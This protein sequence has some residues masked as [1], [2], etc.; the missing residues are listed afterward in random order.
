MRY[1]NYLFRTYK[2]LLFRIKY[3]NIQYYKTGKKSTL[4][5]VFSQEGQDLYLFSLL[6]KYI[7][8]NTNINFGFLDIGANHP[9]INSNSALFELFPNM[10]IYAFEPQEKY[11]ELWKN[12]RP[13]S[14]FMNK[15]VGEKNSSIKLFIPK[16][17]S[18]AYA[19]I[20]GGHS[21]IQDELVEK[22][23]EMITLDHFMDSKKSTKFICA[24]IDVE[25]YELEVLKGINLNK[26]RIGVL[27]LENNC[28]NI[29]G[30]DNIRKFII[31][32]DYRYIAR[33]GYYDDV[34]VSEDFFKNL[35][36]K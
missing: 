12:E 30:D 11:L 35:N 7:L 26:N 17:E 4:L 22:C 36:I 13:K 1:L 29:F 5:N 24:S 14:V 32:N 34:F 25:G 2:Y 28:K 33:I 16:N 6:S 27:L 9:F 10:K 20:D 23:V 31:N 8:N 18:D 15:V 3:P 19:F 21:K